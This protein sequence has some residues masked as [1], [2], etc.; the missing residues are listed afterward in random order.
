MPGPWF[1]DRQLSRAVLIG[2]A[3]FRSADLPDLP[4]VAHNLD[5]LRQV[6]TDAQHG[7][8]EQCTVLAD[9]EV[10]DAKVGAAIAEAAREATDLLLVYY[11]GHGVLDEDGRLHLAR[12]DTSLDHIGWTSVSVDLLKRDVVRARARARV[13]V[14][15]CCFSGRAVAAMSDPRSLLAG[16]LALADP[17]GPVVGQRALSGT[18]TLTSTTATA[19]SHA[20]PGMRYTSFTNALLGALAQ[21]NPLTLDEIYQRISAELDGLG[22]PLPQHN[23]TGDAATLALARGLVPASGTPLPPPAAPPVAQRV[24]LAARPPSRARMTAT[25]AVFVLGLAAIGT[26][27]AVLASGRWGAVFSWILLLLGPALL[28]APFR[29]ARGK[30]EIQRHH[31]SVQW[32]YG[33]R[34]DIAWQRIHQIRVVPVDRPELRMP[35]CD[36]EIELGN[37]SYLPLDGGPLKRVPDC[38]RPTYWF[39]EIDTSPRRLVAALRQYLPQQARMG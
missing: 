20:P 29:A 6:L 34:T 11:A 13:L 39:G 35:R 15:D 4:A 28:L 30:L 1:P 2:T 14:L 16:Q 19:P 37:A 22:L 12:P 7:V 17:R 31:L 38:E 8:V 10:T 24:F 33:R 5:A 23:A 21:P 9:D 32:Q 36:I 26:A 3:A 25:W 18:Y 27:S